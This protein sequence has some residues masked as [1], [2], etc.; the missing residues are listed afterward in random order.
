MKNVEERKEDLLK[1][2]NSEFAK[3]MENSKNINNNQTYNV[4]YRNIIDETSKFIKNEFGITD[5]MATSVIFEYMLWNGYFSKNNCYVFSQKGRV[6]NRNNYGADIMRGRGVCLNIAWMLNDLLNNAGIS[7]YFAACKVK[8]TGEESLVNVDIQRNIEMKNS[9]LNIIAQKTILNIIT[10]KLGNHAVVLV[11]KDDDLFIV[12][13][14]NLLFLKF[15]DFLISKVLN[16]PIECILKPYV[17]LVA[18]GMNPEELLNILLKT[19]DVK[20]KNSEYLWKDN[21]EEL[22]EKNIDLCEKNVSLLKDF[23]N[24]IYDDIDVVCKT[25]KK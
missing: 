2:F 8:K 11:E 23:H 10:E 22:Y 19:D 25:L 7:S 9:L 4:A 3:S 18:T 15:T 17:T 6:N 13:P 14:T 20:N 21:I 5:S 12:D 16:R 1:L 24:Q